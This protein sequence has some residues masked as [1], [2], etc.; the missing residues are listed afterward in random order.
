M[1][2]AAPAR[3]ASHNQ[4]FHDFIGGRTVSSNYLRVWFGGDELGVVGMILD[5]ADMAEEWDYCAQD[6]CNCT[7]PTR[8]MMMQKGESE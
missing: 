4:G 2:A 6:P 5:A 7:T 3:N 8:C 1:V